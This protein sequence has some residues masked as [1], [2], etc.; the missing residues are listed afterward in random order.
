M[1]LC[2]HELCQDVPY[3]AQ[4]TAGLYSHVRRKHLGMVV[5]CPYCPKKLYWNTKG[6]AT[7]MEKFHP[8][9]PHYGHQVA[10]EPEMAAALLSQVEA[11][12][13]AL[14]IQARKQEKRLQKGL[15]PTKKVATVTMKEEADPIALP[16]PDDSSDDDE[17]YQ[18]PSNT[19]DS[20]SHSTSSSDESSDPGQSEKPESKTTA[21]EREPLTFD[22]LQAVR[23]GATALRGQPTL[24][25]LIKH[26]SAWKWQPPSHMASRD[27]PPSTTPAA[28]LATSMVMMDAPPP[29][30]DPYDE[31]VDMPE[32]EETPPPPFPKRRRTKED[33]D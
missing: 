22:Q 8:D 7:H 12:P 32:L 2:R 11:N 18:L 17:D 6:W 10:N 13:D 9:V 3:Y 1:Y 19:A 26:P 29:A 21:P 4:S 14:K 20:S 28:Q 15:H 25:A 16:K 30:K 33:Q 27:L 24:E 5:A 31:P 23:E